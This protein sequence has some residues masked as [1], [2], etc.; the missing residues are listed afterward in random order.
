MC[1]QSNVEHHV[2]VDVSGYYGPEP[3]F[4]TAAGLRPVPGLRLA[5]SRDGT[6]GWTTKFGDGTIRRIDPVAS[7]PYASQATA[8]VLNVVATRADELGYAT[9]YP[10]DEEVPDSSAV[11]YAPGGLATNLVT[12]DL[13][14]DSEI[15]FFTLTGVDL[16]VDLFGVMA[17]PD[18]ALTERFSF[19]RFTWPAFAVDS[20]DYAVQCG[21]R[22]STLELELDLLTS[23]TAR[24]NGV[25]VAAGEIDLV[26]RPDVLTSVQLTRGA[27][28]RTYWFRCLPDEFPPIEVERSGEPT[29]GWYL[30]A[31]IGQPD[32]E[33]FTVIFN[34]HGA[35]VW[36]KRID[37]RVLN[38]TRRSDGRLLYVPSPGLAY[39]IDATNSYWVTSLSGT[40]IEEHRTVD[41][42]ADPGVSYP[43]DH[44]DYVTLAGDR[45]AMLTYP[46]LEG[47]DLTALGPGYGADE[48]IVD[49]VI[50]EIDD[51]DDILLWSWRASDHFGYDEVT[52]PV[53]FGLYSGLDEVD[54]FHL[55]SL[56]LVGDGS[57]DYVVSARHLD[58]VFR[59]DRDT[60]DVSWILANPAGDTSPPD[61]RRL[62]IV[63]DPLDGP[64]RPHDARLNGDVLTLFDNRTDTG[65]PA[66]AV[67]YRI[68][69]A[70]GTATLLWQIDEPG[71]RSSMGLGSA[72]VAADGSVLVDW[73]AL[74]QPMFEE[75][76][77]DGTSLLRIS[78][79]DGGSSYRIVK[80]PASAFS[81][82][83]LRATAGGTADAP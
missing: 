49:G 46:L 75:F 33:T 56:G 60:G 2:I 64:R 67:A 81:A 41:D 72:R 51:N 19:D 68:D 36:Y 7:L 22:T 28:S 29:P 54:P 55:N 65:E 35:P 18:D 83:V 37:R 43:T 71:G 57:G 34:Q 27:T 38:L 69:E 61:P 45:R 62:E 47:Q 58:A 30:T 4:G 50:Q 42:P 17:A 24:V 11:N 13:S 40:L 52:Y 16:V 79:L 23:T 10:C 70:A 15:C 66:R 25:R 44:H 14:R 77:A 6:G 39:G 63:D 26:V 8:V 82:A 80:E 32:K 59:I 53:R 78:Q 31:L 48:W 73:G 3:Q 12:V 9:V 1:V 21:N 20:T 74:L 76:D 5:D